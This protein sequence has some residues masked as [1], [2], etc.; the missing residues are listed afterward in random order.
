VTRAF[1]FA[2]RIK[3]YQ[4]TSKSPRLATVFGGFLS[5][6]LFS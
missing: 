2:L 4:R 6:A 1:V 3:L 5:L